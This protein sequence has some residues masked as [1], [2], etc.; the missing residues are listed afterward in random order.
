MPGGSFGHDRR[1]QLPLTCSVQPCPLLSSMG[2]VAM[3]SLSSMENEDGKGAIGKGGCAGHVYLS[4]IDT[5]PNPNPFVS[6]KVLFGRWLELC[7]MLFTLL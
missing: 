7:Y 5:D 6:L 2:G 1:Y 3:V 4:L